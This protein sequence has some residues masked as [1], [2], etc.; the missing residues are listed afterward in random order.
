MQNTLEKELKF[1]PNYYRIYTPEEI[2]E[3]LD[4]VVGFE[5]LPFLKTV[6]DQRIAA[7]AKDKPNA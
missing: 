5:E 7:A 6:E 4:S 2:E 3:S 1:N